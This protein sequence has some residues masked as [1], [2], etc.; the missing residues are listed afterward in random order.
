MAADYK[1]LLGLLREWIE[2]VEKE[3]GGPDELGEVGRAIYD[4]AIAA[5][6]PSKPKNDPAMVHTWD[7]DSCCSKHMSK[8]ARDGKLDALDRWPCPKCDT[9]WAKYTIHGVYFWKP[10]IAVMVFQP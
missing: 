1:T 10:V 5:I 8:A 9:E 7:N 6:E 2:Y 3:L 4:R